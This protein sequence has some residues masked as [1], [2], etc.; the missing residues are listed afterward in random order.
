[1]NCSPNLSQLAQ[2]TVTLQHCQMSPVGLLHSSTS[3]IT[4]VFITIKCRD[5]YSP[6]QCHGHT[7]LGHQDLNCK[8]NTL[9]PLILPELSVFTRSYLCFVAAYSKSP[10]RHSSHEHKIGTQRQCLEDITTPS[11]ATVEC[12]RYLAFCDGS[13]VS[14]AIERC[15][16]ALNREA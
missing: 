13:T 4:S 15:R 1:M 10:Y 2:H 12:D 3:S 14:K 7:Q 5:K 16:D 9:L 11:H 6:S 8:F